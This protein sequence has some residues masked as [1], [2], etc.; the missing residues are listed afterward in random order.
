MAT[1]IGRFRLHFEMEFGC[2]KCDKCTLLGMFGFISSET[3]RRTESHLWSAPLKSGEETV[4][5]NR[6]FEI[7]SGR[8]FEASALKS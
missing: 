1:E 6:M 8:H 2:D 3:G 4:R 7:Q 5:A